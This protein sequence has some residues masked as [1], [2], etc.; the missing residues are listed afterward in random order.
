MRLPAARLPDPPGR[1]AVIADIHGNADALAAVLAEIDR[2]GLR[3]VVNLGD[4][5][6]GPLDPA[7]TA[8]LLL[9]RPE[10]VCIR[11]NH[12]RYLLENPLDQMSATDRVSREALD[13]AAMGWLRALPVTA[14]LGDY[15]YLCHARPA[16]DDAYLMEVIDGEGVAERPAEAV[17]ADLDGIDAGLV[18]CGHSHLQRAMEVGGR[19]A[20][21]PGSVGC[22]AYSD[23]TPTPH[24][25]ETGSPEAKWAVVARSRE[26]WGVEF[27]ST[28]YD[29]ARMV[30]MAR[31]YGRED[32]ARAVRTGWIRG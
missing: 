7:G 26:G 4:H 15:V 5:L 16:Q 20:V 2:E 18:L 29:A 9:A 3:F 10:M 25:V 24:A 13:V 6:S 14:W 8:E 21:N 27:R 1:F 28:R 32:W 23:D 19:L 22:P 30:A 17:S 31:A 11:G 12:D